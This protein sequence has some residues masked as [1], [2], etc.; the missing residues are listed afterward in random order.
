[1]FIE[2]YSKLAYFNRLKALCSEFLQQHSLTCTYSESY[3]VNPKMQS[4]LFCCNGFGN[5]MWAIYKVV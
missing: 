5:A 1:M 2:L 3:N 4:N